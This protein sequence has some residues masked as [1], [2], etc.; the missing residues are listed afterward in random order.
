[1]NSTPLVTVIIPCYNRADYIRQTVDS[2]LGQDYPSKELIVVDDGSTDDSFSI[3]ESVGL[4]HAHGDFVAILDSDDLFLPGKLT[5]QVR[6]LQEHPDI[7]VVYANGMNI[8][9]SGE[10]MYP[11]H[12]ANVPP[13]IGPEPVLECCAYNLPSNAL[14]RKEVFDEAGFLEESFRTAQ[15]HDMAIRLAEV[16]PVGYLDEVLWCYR[17]HEASVSHGRTVERWRNGF[18][19]LKKAAERYPYPYGVKRRRRA[20]LHFRMG[21][22]LL[23]Q[24]SF[25]RAALHLVA[26]GV[27]DPLRGLKVIS[28]A[29]RV[30]APNS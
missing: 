12:P 13:V 16:A 9:A 8:S 14:V 25:G 20:V 26:A 7:G 5:K 22:C 15:D 17:R 23:Q 19:I 29:E 30:D 3:L 1:M 11:V 24:R 4:R 18:V 10:D 28:G 6:Y 27:L 21:Q 2:V